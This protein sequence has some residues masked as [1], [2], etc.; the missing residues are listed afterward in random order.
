[1]KDPL[2]YLILGLPGSGRR[3]VVADLVAAGLDK[4]EKAAIYLPTSEG[5]HASDE[6]LQAQ[7]KATVLGWEFSGDAFEWEDLPGDADYVFWVLDGWANMADQL[8]LLEKWIARQHFSLARVIAVVHCQAEIDHPKLKAYHDACA[9]F[10]D[11]MLLNRRED[12]PNKWVKDFI[13]RYQKEHLPV[14]IE[15]VKKGKVPNPAAVLEPEARRV[16]M[17]FD[18]MDTMDAIDELEFD[19]GIEEVDEPFDI[20]GKADPWLERLPGGQRRKTLPDVR[21]ILGGATE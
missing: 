10:A 16:T 2:F 7:E 12:A 8:E 20:E 4:E 17:L 5:T 3:E 6:L 19:E 13:E 18:E 11:S 14:L 9:H 15:Y 21:S 1:M